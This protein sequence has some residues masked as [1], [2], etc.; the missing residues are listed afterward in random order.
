MDTQTTLMS[1]TQEDQLSLDSPTQEGKSDLAAALRADTANS[2]KLS[3]PGNKFVIRLP[4]GLRKKILLIS[5]R[6]S[7]SMNSEIVLVLGRYFE[8]QLSE[9]AEDDADEALEARL[10]RKLQGLPAEKREALLALLE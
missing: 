8:N 10:R 9:C 1:E 6:H 3:Q 7:R 4:E 2:D 5:R